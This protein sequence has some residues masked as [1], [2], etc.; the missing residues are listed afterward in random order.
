MWTAH[1]TRSKLR[2]NCCATRS[3]AKIKQSVLSQKKEL[4]D[5]RNKQKPRGVRQK[6]EGG[7]KPKLGCTLGLPLVYF[8]STWWKFLLHLWTILLISAES[9]MRVHHETRGSRLFSYEIVD[10]RKGTACQW[11]VPGWSHLRAPREKEKKIPKR[12]TRLSHLCTAPNNIRWTLL[13]ASQ[14]I[15]LLIKFPSSP[16]LIFLL[17]ISSKVQISMI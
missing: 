6:R 17:R 10:L 8:G 13:L 7:P 1:A 12:L 16:R 9:L 4:L 14:N 2:W 11:F 3:G 15:H 5:E